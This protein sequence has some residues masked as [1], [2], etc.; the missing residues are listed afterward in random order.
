VFSGFFILS[1]ATANFGRANRSP[2]QGMSRNTVLSP[3]DIMDGKRPAMGPV[4]IF[5]DDHYYFGSVIA[6]LL[7]AAGY[8]VT[9]VTPESVVA[10]WTRYTLEQGHIEERMQP[11]IPLAKRR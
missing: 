9:I 2:I 5:D 11:G 1:T 6:E 4:V 10:D 7:S 8:A 3:D